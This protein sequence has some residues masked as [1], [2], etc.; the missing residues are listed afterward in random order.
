MVGFETR[1]IPVSGRTLV[2]VRLREAISEMEE[3]IVVGY[4]T[5]KKQEVSTAI[6]QI[7]GDDIRKTPATALT[8]SLTGK[9][10]GLYTQQRS[11]P[12]G[13]AGAA[14]IY[15][16]RVATFTNAS[17]QH[18]ILVEDVEQNS[19]QFYLIDPKQVENGNAARREKE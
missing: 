10:P 8:N 9:I 15:I 19:E 6:S 2:D 17:K 11:G 18:L 12:P 4:G 16:R 13:A 14:E 7:Q 1:E 5:Q 3:I